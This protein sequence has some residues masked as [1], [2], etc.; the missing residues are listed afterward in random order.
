MS[1][2]YEYFDV[3]G[4]GQTLSGYAFPDVHKFDASSFY[5]WEQDNLPVLD[6]ETR[7]NV[8]RQY[9]GLTDVTGVTL[10]VSADAPKSASSL[11]VYQT[12]QDA[13]EVVPRRLRF[14]LLIEICDFGNLGDLNL[15]DIHCEGDGA[16]QIE[17]RQYAP[18]IF[19]GFVS[20]VEITSEAGPSGV[21]QTMITG[22]ADS[23]S[24]ALGFRLETDTASNI[25]NASSTNLGI[26]CSSLEGWSR[27]A[28]IFAA[29]RPNSQDETQCITF[30]PQT[31]NEVSSLF[32]GGALPGLNQKYTYSPYSTTEEAT[33]ALDASPKTQNGAGQSLIEAR[34]VAALQDK[35][36]ASWWGAYF[37]KIEIK[38]CSKIKL[39]NICVDSASGLDSQYPSQMSYLC[40]TG[41]SITN[42]NVL[43]DNIAVCR[44]RKTGI[45]VQDSTVSLTGAFI[46]HRVYERNLNGTR[47][48]E[49]VGLFAA[50][51]NIV[52]DTEDT[53]LA[54]GL[55]NSESIHSISKCG[56]GILLN[57]SLL[58]GGALDAVSTSKNAGPTDARSTRLYVHDNQTGIKLVNSVCDM[59]GRLE[60]F[61]NINGIEAFQS[62]LTFQQ[63]SVDTNQERGFY[64]NHSNLFYGKDSD[65]IG[66]FSSLSGVTKP[67]FACDYNGINIHADKNSSIAPH[68]GV[69]YIPSLARWGGKTDRVQSGAGKWIMSNH[70]TY[71]LGA[72]K[73]PNIILN[74]NSDAEFTHLAVAF[75]GA[76][77]GVAGACVQ[78]SE[79]SQ[80][81]FR[82]TGRSA[83]CM[84]SYGDVTLKSNWTTAAVAALDNSEVVF[85]GPTKIA[86]AGVGVLAQNNSRA[87]FGP[88][89]RDHTV[90]TPAYDRFL[91]SS[92]DNHTTVDIHANRSCLVA[93]E[94]SLIEIKSL[95]GSSLDADN[96][97]DTNQTFDASNTFV[98][99]TSGSYIRFSPNGFTEQLAASYY[100][101]DDFNLFERNAAAFTNSNHQNVTTGGM[102]VRAVGASKVDVNMTNFRIGTTSLPGQVSG[103]CY[104]YNGT[105]CEYAPLATSG[106]AASP[107]FNICDLVTSCCDPYPTTTTTNTTVTTT[108]AP[109]TTTTTITGTITAP[110]VEPPTETWKANILET[111]VDMGQEGNNV[112]DSD[113]KG[114]DYEFSCVGSRIHMWNIADTSRMHAAN[115]LLNGSNP[116]TECINNSFHG[117]TGRW[118]NGAACDYY[119][120]LGFAASALS[121]KALGS[122]VDGF[123]N[124]G[125][126]RVI[127]SHRGYLKTYSEVDYQGLAINSQMTQGGSPMDQVNSQGYQTMFDLA[128]NTPGADDNV[129]YHVGLEPGSVSG[130]EPVF[131]RGLAGEPGQPGK[132]NG[133][134][135]HARMVEGEGMRWDEG[136]LHPI[137]PFPPLHLG[138][139]GYIRNWLDES[140]ANVFANARHGASKKVNLLSIYRSSTSSDIGG[141]G[142]DTSTGNPT[143]GVGVRSLNMFD[144]NR[145]V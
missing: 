116:E 82:G 119:G 48:S 142:R 58:T 129:S 28:R 66:G 101:A 92:T 56:Q 7:S 23:A 124:L 20:S 39:R 115:L 88:P 6:L 18:S 36:I 65:S 46:I 49:G 125:V 77:A 98:E 108:A 104:N 78:V 111:V 70:G 15:A 25:G 113:F 2:L 103:V 55:Y 97:T 29:R 22:H 26:S 130:A 51:S 43:L 5:N 134:M 143:F 102:C 110:T 86:R 105:G 123:Y 64:L 96:S 81:V 57:N 32:P 107:A 121:E 16:L 3:T 19:R 40:D 118:A 131:G 109:T 61:S 94:K 37:N 52:F 68:D 106:I 76:A 4:G 14:P 112:E 126:F 73:A 69:E 117:P 120:N 132:L 63:F 144:L 141:E 138:W 127:G 91:L 93:N 21:L 11:G 99:S 72:Y 140:A 79:N 145:L 47:T 38:N 80:A 30:S 83:T 13:L 133:V 42:S 44:V 135:T 45:N 122:Q 53:N 10:T 27:N 59:N 71:G 9:L 12:V 89:T 128:I 95:G 87:A 84:G 90:W 136:E 137:F 85:T 41:I 24:L 67:A 75:N 62:N 34:R 17:C 100:G 33:I 50:D 60:V 8:L 54:G 114:V 1:Q 74:N 139:Q 35:S 31:N